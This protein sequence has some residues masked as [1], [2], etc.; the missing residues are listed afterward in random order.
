MMWNDQQLIALQLAPAAGIPLTQLHKIDRSLKFVMPA[1]GKK[2]VLLR[3]DLKQR[4]R[5]DEWI[6]RQV[7]RTEITV[8]NFCVAVTL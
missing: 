5:S 6:K 7:A 8:R 4:A 2:P 1:S 3:V